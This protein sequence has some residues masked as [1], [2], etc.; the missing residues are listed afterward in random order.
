MNKIKLQ[1]K[2]EN[3]PIITD[4]GLSFILD[5]IK[6]LKIKKV[7]EIGT[8][9]GYSAISFAMN[10]CS[11]L[12]LERN[13]LMYE[14]AL[15]NIKDY[16]LED[17]IEVIFTDALLFELDKESKFDLI[18]IDAAKAQY[19]K[20]FNKYQENLNE[21]GVII[22]DNLNFHNLDINKVSRSTRQLIGK[23]ERFKEFLK[24]NP[25][26]ETTF[27]NLGDGMSVSKKIW[28]QL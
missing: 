22:C 20:F 14:K 3:V 23:I 17:K 11:V 27:Y 2:N 9:I 7:L 25:N 10:G 4:E 18:F 1:A 21:N 28:K 5:K 15:L 12:T 13:N 16:I 26:Y 19:E 8:A 6:E 24:N